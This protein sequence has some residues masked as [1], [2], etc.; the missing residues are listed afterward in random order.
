[1]SRWRYRVAELLARAG[2]L[3]LGQ[4]MLSR[5][6]DLVVLA[7]HRIVPTNIIESGRIDD[8]L[9]S[10]TPAEFAEQLAILSRH[11]AV[12][13]LDEVRNALYRRRRLRPESILITFDDGFDD[14]YEHA[15]PA[16]KA[17]NLPYA[18]FLATDMVG[19]PQ[20]FWYER[21]FVG[22][23]NYPGDTLELPPPVGTVALGDIP[24]RC[25]AAAAMVNRLKSVGNAERESI[26]AAIDQLASGAGRETMRPISRPIS[27]D[28][29]RALHVGGAAIGSHTCSH[30]ILSRCD[31]PRLNRELTESKRILEAWTRS[32]VRTLAYPNGQTEDIGDTVRQAAIDAGYEVAFSTIAGSN[33]LPAQDP[34]MIK[35]ITTGTGMGRW[36]FR[37]RVVAAR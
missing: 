5:S 24:Q 17:A 34:M 14:L 1:M 18:V 25:A 8:G 30:P 16:L 32:P 36:R 10:A 35:R 20:S 29:L 26:V 6:H 23:R 31:P 27:L 11:F 37:G 4:S 9:V 13:T 2:A 19:H 3:G 12:V 21:V 15:R 33:S 7:Y 22:V 28:E